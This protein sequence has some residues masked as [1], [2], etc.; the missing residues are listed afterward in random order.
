MIRNENVSVS[1]NGQY[2]YPDSV[3][4]VSSVNTPYGS[5]M[6]TGVS[7]PCVVGD[8][9][10]VVVNGITYAYTI[11]ENTYQP[12]G[13]SSVR[14]LANTYML[15]TK[16]VA[17][18][19]TLYTDSNTLISDNAG[20]VPV[21]N[22][23]PN[24]LFNEVT[25]DSD[26]SALGAMLDML[27]VI[28][29]EYYEQNGT[30][31]L[32]K[33]KTISQNETPVTTILDSEVITHSFTDKV[34]STNQIKNVL[35]NPITDD[36]YSIPQVT[37]DFDSEKNTG[38]ILFNPSI[39]ASSKYIIQGITPTPFNS[40]SSAIYYTES[41]ELNAETV[42]TTLGGIDSIVSIS[43]NDEPVLESDYENYPTHNKVRF[44]TKRTGQCVIKYQTNV[45]K[46][47]ITTDTDV[48]IRYK[49]AL[50]NTK[51]DYYSKSYTD[52]ETKI[53]VPDDIVLDNG[54]GTVR[55]IP[56]FIYGRDGV[57]LSTRNVNYDLI[58]YDG[59]YA[60]DYDNLELITTYTL[61]S[62][63]V[64]NVYAKYKTG[65]FWDTAFLYNA[66]MESVADVVVEQFKVDIQP[67]TNGQYQYTLTEAVNSDTVNAVSA[68]GNKLTR[69]D[70]YDVVGDLF[71]LLK[72]S[73]SD[74][75]FKISYNV[76]KDKI[77]FP[78]PT[79]DNN[80]SVIQARVDGAS[81]SLDFLNPSKNLCVVPSTIT[82]SI[83]E[84][85]NIS[86]AQAY[87]GRVKGDFGELVVDYF[88]NVEVYISNKR[89]YVLDTSEI[90]PFSSITIDAR[91]VI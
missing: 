89:I 54:L 23:I 56:P 40:T 53:T 4:I 59:T 68:D 88:G 75:V 25:Y 38:I 66:R 84:K 71:I 63:A 24:I 9:A 42:V 76:L 31:F 62:N 39:N 44:L 85:L 22:N 70:E 82:V 69:G 29:G 86:V 13:K 19:S 80:V 46:F 47:N 16:E 51:L 43:I 64:A 30:L 32:D 79:P 18:S 52:P 45:L 1:I 58:F 55:I 33:F 77:V 57:I 73:L 15:E 7:L 17:I 49:T 27:S 91:G 21:V 90:V 48:L 3:S 14:G 35:I 36:I 8:V 41:F 12:R 11:T 78:L 74:A 83:A 28:S 5:L 60:N 81:T 67:N 61:P 65:F 20:N 37:I 34:G 2:I 6:L 26:G 50:L 87:G 10:N 72:D